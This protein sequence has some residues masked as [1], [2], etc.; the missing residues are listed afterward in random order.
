MEAEATEQ[1]FVREQIG[2]T[3]TP[4]PAP[5][6]IAERLSVPVGAGLVRRDMVLMLDGEPAALA[7]S[8]F[9]ADLVEGSPIVRPEKVPGG[10]HGE[11]ARLAGELGDARE[12]LVARM[13]TPS[14]STALRL[15]PGTP[16]VELWRTIPAADGRI[17]ETTR[18]RFDGARYQ[19]AYTVP[20]D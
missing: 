17:L 2:I 16:I 14:E 13:P 15:P 19:F 1:G 7:S 20:M 9:R 4:E 18:F 3:V 10:V 11:L 5:G 6:A 8:W 12:E